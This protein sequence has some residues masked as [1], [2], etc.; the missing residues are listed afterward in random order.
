MADW[1]TMEKYKPSVLTGV[2]TVSTQWSREQCKGLYNPRRDSSRTVIGITQTGDTVP[3][4]VPAESI[5]GKLPI[6]DKFIATGSQDSVYL[7]MQKR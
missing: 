3:F 2:T 5:L 6:I 4:S 7:M 1:Y